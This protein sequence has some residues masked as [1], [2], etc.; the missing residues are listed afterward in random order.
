LEKVDGKEATI[1]WGPLYNVSRDELLVLRKTL[2]DLLNKGFIRVSSSSAAALVLFAKKPGGRLRFCV[3]Y[4]GLNALSKK[5][6]YPLPLIYETLRGIGRAHWFSKFDVVAAFHKIRMAKGEEWMTAFRTRYGLYE[7]LVT[8]FGLA[9]APSTFQRYINWALRGYLDEFRSA[10]VDD[11]LVYTAGSLK[12]HR[13]HVNQVLTRLQ[14]AG[15]HLDIGKSEFE[16]KSTKYLGFIIEAGKGVRMDPDKIKAI[17]EWEAPKTVKGVR[18]FLGFANFYRKF[19]RNFSDVVR[20]LTALTLKDAPFQWDRSAQEAFERLKK[21]FTEGS[22]L[23]SFDYDLGTVLETES[24]GW[25][26]GGVLMQSGRDGVLRP[27]GFFSKKNNSAECNYEIYDKEMLAIIR[28]LEEWEVELKSVR[29][30]E[31]RTDHKN[32]EYFITAKK[33]TERQVRWSLKL[34]QFNF[35]LSYLPGKDN[36]R[37]DA[38]SRRDQDIP[39]GE[40][41]ERL[42]AR[43]LQLLKPETLANLPKNVIKVWVK[44]VTRSHQRA[45][46]RVPIA[47]TTDSTS[48]GGDQVPN[49]LEGIRRDTPEIS[50]PI[51]ETPDSN[52][53]AFGPDGN[54]ANDELSTLWEAA[55]ESDEV[56]QALVGAMWK[57]ERKFPSKIKQ[58]VSMNECSL[59]PSGKL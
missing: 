41:D 33:L 48:E 50:V 53:L 23:A 17:H 37:A 14:E 49:V 45:T 16:V 42:Q 32:L 15:L 22:L 58:Q 18:G 51:N 36:E 20:P 7:W 54:I 21:M 52:E 10:Y 24:S 40:S 13:D 30:F 59:T 56:Y 6:R 44:P 11:I 34:S 26:V 2:T 9:N 47:Q 28:C 43:T 35:K 19:I 4:G 3:D 27:C 12:K 46:A 55:E 25:C 1:P 31:I 8:P 5:D 39:Q 57:G 29:D 38:L